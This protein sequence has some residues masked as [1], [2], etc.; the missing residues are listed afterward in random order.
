M[1]SRFGSFNCWKATETELS[2][3][4][5]S[6]IYTNWKP[7]FARLVLLS[8]A[9]LIVYGL[10]LDVDF[11]DAKS[12]TDP[13][14]NDIA[15]YRAVVERLQA[16]EDFYTANGD[17]QHQRGYPTTPFLTWRLPTE[18]WIISLLGETGA[19]HLLQLLLLLAVLAWV[20]LLM[21]IGLSRLGVV[22]GAWLVCSSLMIVL[23]EP[24]LYLHEAWAAAFIALSLP[25]QSRWW[26]L[27]V[28]FGLAAL[29]FRELALPYA[30]AMATCAWW[31]GRAREAVWWAVGIL[32]F[33]IGLA[34][35]AWAVSGQIGPD[36]RAGGGWLALGGW[37]FLLSANQLN[38]IIIGT[39]AWLTAIWVPLALLGASVRRDALGLRL[40]LI[41]VGYSFAF[42]FLGR[43]NNAYWG[44]IYGPLVAVSLVFAPGALRALWI[45]AMNSSK[46]I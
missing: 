40:F 21:D 28:I 39:G 15:L 3:Q 25:L 33:A 46:N 31:E 1:F 41:V 32:I 13:E 9:F 22:C 19:T 27:S 38:L 7:L 6:V 18:A 36:A 30:L 8:L 2:R 44:M 17:E 16:G 12:T 43:D 26:R 24:S 11:L 34:L 35:H 10:W 29:A 4:P 5:T 14:S 42:L 23:A 20:K 37:D 45:A